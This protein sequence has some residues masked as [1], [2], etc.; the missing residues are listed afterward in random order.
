MSEAPFIPEWHR[1]PHDAAGFFG[2]AAGFERRDLKRRYNEFIRQFKPEKFPQEFQR[3]RAAYEQL[4]LGLRSFE[5]DLFSALQQHHDEDADYAARK[6][7][8]DSLRLWAIGQTEAVRRS[9]TLFAVPRLAT[10]GVKD[11]DESEHETY[12]EEEPNALLPEEVPVF[13]GAMRELFPQHYAMV[14]LEW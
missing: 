10:E 7:R 11:F 14:F 4:D 12:S 6:G 1:L 5:L 3:I 2:L 8:T 13:L 9:L